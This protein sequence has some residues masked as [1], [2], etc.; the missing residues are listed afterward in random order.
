[1]L[2]AD[3]VEARVVRG[4]IVPAYVGGDGSAL[5]IAASAIALFQD[6]VG[7]SRGELESELRQLG[8]VRREYLLQ[9]GFAKLLFDRCEFVTG[10][11]DDL[12]APELRRRV[13]SAAARRWLDSGPRGIDADA[14]RAELAPQFGLDADALRRL[15][16]ADLKEEQIIA[17]F[18]ALSPH[19]LVERYDLA[20]CQAVLLRATRLEVELPPQS[21]AV[22]RALFRAIKFHQLLFE[23][24]GRAEEGYRIT[25][26]GPLSLFSAASKYGL[27]LAQFVPHLLHAAGFAARAT[28]AWGQS[29]TLRTFEF[30][31]QNGFAPP[32][33]LLGG[34]VPEELNWFVEQFTKLE[35]EW[36]VSDQSEI[37]D[38]GGRG[39]LVADF[40][41]THRGTGLVVPFEVLG[42][43]RRSALESRLRLIRQ[44][45]TADLLLGIGR[46]LR[47]DEESLEDLPG[48]VYV[49]R[50]VP[51][52]REVRERLDARL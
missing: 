27:Q 37:V 7:R 8:G 47:V 36:N 22:Y 29:R 16:Y 28:V 31:H 23:V 33:R 3:L 18:D 48:E 51:I 5:E 35:S 21:A 34:F 46:D 20:L 45:G 13:F 19:E 40:V 50:S 25:L 12:D 26:D 32:N 38:L 10:L 14:L 41:F 4:K 30:S 1:M 9:R 24:E 49:F 44:H 2:T 39:V 11:S 15:L 52:A 43:W 42:Y 17:K 6:A